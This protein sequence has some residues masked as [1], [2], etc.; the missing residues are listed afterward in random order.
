MSRLQQLLHHRVTRRL[1]KLAWRYRWL[2]PIVSFVG[3][4]VSFFLVSRQQSLGTW[5]ALALACSWL[6]LVGESLWSLWN[7]HRQRSGLPRLVA[8]F[9]GQ[10]THQETLFFC[11]PFFLVA[12]VWRSGQAVFTGLLVVCAIVSII[13]PLYFRM[14]ERRRWLYFGYHALCVFVMA[15]VIGP[16]LFQLTTGHSL[17][18][19]A[20]VLPLVA[21][22]TLAG[23]TR[24]AGAARWA[25]LPVAAVVL[26]L[27]AWSLRA[28]IPPATLWIDASALSPGFDSEARQPVGQ[29]LATTDR[30]K[31]Q[32]LYAYTAIH[33]PL[34][35][36]ETVSHVWRHRGEV[37]DRIELAIQGGREQG[38]RAWSHKQNF[39]D[40]ASGPWQVD[41]MTQTG[42]RLGVIRFNVAQ[43][44]EQA[45]RLDGTIEQA[46]GVGWLRHGEAP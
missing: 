23:L 33:A 17:M 26:G 46:P 7:R 27:G 11:L 20:L 30:L 2:W 22:P 10:L 41:I 42:Q 3:G 4:I 18:L 40:N 35:L 28:F 37:V 39:G 32:G 6:L 25:L 14:A 13:D 45:Q 12:T 15:L 43:E 36:D 44:P 38:Y 34:G 1:S 31:A 16:L 5:L 29:M 19:A 21:L 8:N 9:C 24:P